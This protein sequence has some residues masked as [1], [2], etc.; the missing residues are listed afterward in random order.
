[1]PYSLILAL[2][3]LGVALVTTPAVIALARRS[4][5]FDHPGPRRIHREPVPTLGGLAMVVAVLGVAWAARLSPGPAQV[6]EM[7]PLLGL[8][9]AA[10][11]VVLLGIVDDLTGTRPWLKL[12]AQATAA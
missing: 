2:A 3:S 12:V 11:P 9:I 4:G 7:H 6:L 10:I 8:T 5:A 1:M